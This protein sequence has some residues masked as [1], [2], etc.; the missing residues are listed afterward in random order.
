MAY[1]C[2]RRA[3]QGRDPVDLILSMPEEERRIW[4]RSLVPDDT[5]DL[6]QSAPSE[7]GEQFARVALVIGA[8][9][10]GVV[11]FG[12]IVGAMLPLILG[13]F[14]LDPAS[15]SAPAVATLVHVSGLVIYFSIAKVFVLGAPR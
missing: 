2:R 3:V 5:A 1:G 14:R 8:S 9:L 4:L 11:M 10:I 6:I 15:A 13:A 12:T 7:E